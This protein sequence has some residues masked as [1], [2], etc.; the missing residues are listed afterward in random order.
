LCAQWKAA[1]AASE[2][3]DWTR[4]SFYLGI[5]SAVIGGLT[6]VAAAAAASYARDAAVEARRGA[7][8]A[9][10]SLSHAKDI[11]DV[12]IRPYVSVLFPSLKKKHGTWTLTAR[13]IN[14]GTIPAKDV[15]VNIDVAI[16]PFPVPVEPF[17]EWGEPLVFS[18]IA[19]D[20]DGRATI[21]K[22]LSADDE[23]DVLNYEK[24]I[25]CRTF[26]SYRPLPHLDIETKE[27]RTVFFGNNLLAKKARDWPDWIHVGF[28]GEDEQGE[29]PV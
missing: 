15:Q 4:R 29:L 10:L 7:T 21:F 26:L 12:Q 13:V 25:I 3:A 5:G 23:G 28:P 14:S 18:M 6:L 19:A 16:A 20:P 1:D 9:E 24:V 11:S 8:A 17:T 2:S 27:E 22:G